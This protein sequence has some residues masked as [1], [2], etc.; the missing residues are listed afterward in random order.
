MVCLLYFACELAVIESTERNKVQY[1]FHYICKN[2][3]K[4]LKNYIIL[5]LY[6]YNILH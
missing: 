2:K 4:K 6:I 5:L 3:L 1:V